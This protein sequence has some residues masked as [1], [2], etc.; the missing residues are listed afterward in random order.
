MSARTQAVPFGGAQAGRLGG[1]STSERKAA[2]ARL[3]GARGGRPRT[4]APKS[5]AALL[6][7]KLAADT[8]RLQHDITQA[9]KWLYV[10]TDNTVASPT[11]YGMG[12]CPKC[13][14]VSKVVK[15]SGRTS[16]DGAEYGV[17]QTS[18]F[19]GSVPIGMV[20]V[21]VKAGRR[22]TEYVHVSKTLDT[23]VHSRAARV[24]CGDIPLDSCWIEPEPKRK[25]TQAAPTLTKKRIRAIRRAA[26]F[27][28]EMMKELM[29]GVD[30]DYEHLRSLYPDGVHIFC[31][32]P[33]RP[34]YDLPKTEKGFQAEYDQACDE[35][36]ALLAGKATP[37]PRTQAQEYAVTCPRCG[38]QRTAQNPDVIRTL[39]AAGLAG[40]R[41]H[42]TSCGLK[43]P[44]HRFRDALITRAVPAPKTQATHAAWLR[45]QV[46]K[47]HSKSLAT[48]T[49]G[50]SESRTFCGR[51]AVQDNLTTNPTCTIC[52]ARVQRILAARKIM[53]EPKQ[54]KSSGR[55]RTAFYKKAA[56][57]SEQ[58]ERGV[59]TGKTWLNKIEREA[60]RFPDDLWRNI[61]E[62]LRA[63]V[64]YITEAEEKP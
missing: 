1:Q 42:C 38:T 3:N 5:G 61:A 55:N 25:K 54:R 52:K 23:S 19:A 9:D 45:G 39:P 22:G 24:A 20:P 29:D 53:A 10:T 40:P 34:D 13:G 46:L 36:D 27:Y 6:T 56:R 26:K 35:L 28:V 7:E 50:L 59:F 11:S 15:H 63:R 33:P 14:R 51:V 60:E 37:A 4:Q 12:T 16:R 31:A 30:G 21:L 32:Y 47:P 64:K 43:A 41:N 2:A 62:N 8:T 44:V 18:A 57:C 58:W 17:K 49:P 48:E